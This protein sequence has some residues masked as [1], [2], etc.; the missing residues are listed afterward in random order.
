MEPGD[1]V[2]C[3][4]CGEESFARQQPVLDGWTKTGDMLVCSLY[5]HKLCDYEPPKIDEAAVKS[6]AKTAALS[7]LF[8]GVEVEIP[9]ITVTDD[10]R[11]FC[12]DCRS[13]IVHPFMSRCTLHDKQVNP[14]DDCQD[15][16]KND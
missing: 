1:K 7:D 13:F 12:R 3:P 4:E 5:G 2:I 6:N 15:F 11:I 14:M 9:V 10:E 16:H 8:G